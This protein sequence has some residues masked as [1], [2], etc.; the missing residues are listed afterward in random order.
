[1]RLP[2]CLVSRCAVGFNPGGR[3]SI[4]DR[5]YRIT[6]RRFAHSEEESNFFRF[7]KLQGNI[8][9]VGDGDFGYS[10]ALADKVSKANKRGGNTV[11]ITTSSL[12]PKAFVEYKYDEGKNNLKRLAS[13]SNVTVLHKVDA[14]KHVGLFVGLQNWIASYGIFLIHPTNYKCTQ[15][16]GMIF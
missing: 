12:D 13:Y 10:V 6:S 2:S 15:T 4:A 8:L 3:V 11:R 9:V 5:N 1:M 16:K 7:P 14:T